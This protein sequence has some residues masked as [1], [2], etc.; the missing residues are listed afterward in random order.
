MIKKYLFFTS[1]I[2]VILY[3][4]R[5][6]VDLAADDER[7]KIE[8]YIKE[9][10]IEIDTITENGVYY[11]EDNVGTGDTVNSGDFISIN[12]CGCKL[13]EELHNDYTNID[14][15]F[16]VDSGQVIKGINEGVTLM[17]ENTTARLI[18][19][20]EMAYYSPISSFNN[21]NTYILKIYINKIIDDPKQWEINRINNYI[22]DNNYIGQ[23]D[24]NGYCIINIEKGEG[25]II[26]LN[27]K[28]KL[29]YKCK[30]LNNEVLLSSKYDQN[31]FIL[32][33][34]SLYFFNDTILNRPLYNGLTTMKEN[35]KSL[36][37][38]PSN[39]AFGRSYIGTE[40]PSYATF[41][42]EINAI[43]IQ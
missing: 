10:N 15:T 38:I 37:I 12:F 2:L 7:I 9:K 5:N 31:T 43:T 25:E 1:I 20:F 34:D 33:Y 39:K 24:T 23:P 30:L 14:F 41:I 4:C 35:G 36:I 42:F 8:K 3:A 26:N 13:E 16:I 17:R 27:D 40:I 28:V 18:I 32:N 21:Y 19:P 6:E 22:S 11:I 29:D